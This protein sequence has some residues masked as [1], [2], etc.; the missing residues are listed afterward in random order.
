MLSYTDN[1]NNQQNIYF[2]CDASLAADTDSSAATTLSTEETNYALACQAEDNGFIKLAEDLFQEL[3]DYQ[4]SAEH[5][6]KLHDL[7]A[8]YDGTYHGELTQFDG[9][10]AYMYISDGNVQVQY[11]TDNPHIEKNDDVYQLCL[12]GSVDG[13][14]LLAFRDSISTT[15]YKNDPDYYNDPANSHLDNYGFGFS[16]QQLEDGSYIVGATTD[17]TFYTWNGFYDKISDSVE[18]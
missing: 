7:L 1:N 8:P 2:S 4:D 13:E 10:Y 17:S 12:Y 18:Q 5:Y 16:I 11:D 9:V 6:A 14:P 15:R 3:G